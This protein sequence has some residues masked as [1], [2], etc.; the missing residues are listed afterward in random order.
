[1]IDKYFYNLY[2]NFIVLIN[3]LYYFISIFVLF[4]INNLLD[5]ILN[6]SISFFFEFNF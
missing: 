4:F 6:L 5:I 1:M 3:L 2:D